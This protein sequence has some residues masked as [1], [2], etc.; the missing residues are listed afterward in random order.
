M[1]VKWF[2]QTRLEGETFFSLKQGWIG[3]W[4]LTLDECEACTTVNVMAVL[5]TAFSCA[6]FDSQYS[7]LQNQI[8][9]LVAVK[10]RAISPYG[11]FIVGT[12]DYCWA[13]QAVH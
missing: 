4:Y 12:L 13:I 5:S 1:Q 11:T 6:M 9:V 7:F 10:E 8:N 2:E 3:K